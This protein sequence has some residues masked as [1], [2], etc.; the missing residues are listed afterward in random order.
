[1]TKARRITRTVFLILNII[2]SVVFLLACL[3]PHVNP[4][5][6][7]YISMLGLAF[8]VIIVTELAFIFFWLLFKPVYIF[9]ALV[10]LIIGWKS[11]SVFFAV[12][13]PQKFNY[14]KPANV[15]RIADWNVARFIEWK[16]NN[17]KGS[18]TR[19]KM[20][21][22]IK[23]QNAD[24]FTMQEFFTSTDTTYWDN[25][26]YLAKEAGFP[27]H[28]FA[29]SGDGDRQWFGNIIFSKHPIVDSGKF[30]FPRAAYPETLL[31]TDI[32]I[33]N[34][35]IRVYT[36]H[37]QSLKFN[38]EDYESIEMI[39]KDQEVALGRTRGIFSKLKRGITVRHEQADLV[40]DM[41][42][43]DPYP[44]L[45]TGDFND[46]PNS[47]A[48]NTIRGD[49]LQDAFLEK[50]L[51]IGRTFNDIS[52][53]LRIDYILATKDFEVRQFNR[54]LRKLSDHYLVVADVKLKRA[55]SE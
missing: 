21:D 31:H 27:Y 48:Y 1:M 41:I 25:L 6:Y 2:T 4:V 52:P 54:V 55:S 37:L 50:G 17:N 12:N 13:L 28:Y 7:W 26:P 33:G 35:T 9:I 20:I 14:E 24:V 51:G 40:R 43:N 19:M 47:Y 32:K 46:V 16:R 39:K 30:Y 3:S 8:A 38:K 22:L 29:R 34:D 18:Q 10:P 36:T 15:I 5:Q 23:E 45:F 11:L 44:I 49:L 42:N 53:T